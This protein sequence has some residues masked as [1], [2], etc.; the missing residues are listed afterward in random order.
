MSASDSV[1]L[2]EEKRAPN[3]E[4]GFDGMVLVVSADNY[5][6]ALISEGDR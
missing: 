4:S 1:L 3:H 2:R 5:I 6:R